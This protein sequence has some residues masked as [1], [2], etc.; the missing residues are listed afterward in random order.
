MKL[1]GSTVHNTNIILCTF[2]RTNHS[3]DDFLGTEKKWTSAST[4]VHVT[5]VVHHIYIYISKVVLF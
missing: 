2:V 1:N 4:I 3:A 5:S